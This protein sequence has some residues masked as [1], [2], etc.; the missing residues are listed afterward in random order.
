MLGDHAFSLSG[1]QF[2]LL[3]FDNGYI[4]FDP[5]SPFGH[6]LFAYVLHLSSFFIVFG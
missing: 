4:W 2:S 1:L 3:M 5:F 6:C